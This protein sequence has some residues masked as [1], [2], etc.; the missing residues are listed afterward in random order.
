[1]KKILL[2]I[3]IFTGVISFAQ[4]AGKWENVYGQGGIEYGYRVRTCVD[5]GYIVAGSTSSTGM[6][7]LFA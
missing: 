6:V 4:T 3:S 7:I 2:F 5:Q 1:M